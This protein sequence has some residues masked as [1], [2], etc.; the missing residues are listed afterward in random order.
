LDQLRVQSS[1]SGQYKKAIEKAV[2]KKR[3]RAMATKKDSIQEE[4]TNQ[5]SALRAAP[6]AANMTIPRRDVLT[7]AALVLMG[8]A[9]VSKQV[10][11]G[12]AP[13]GSTCR[14]PNKLHTDFM[15]GFTKYF[16]G[17]PA[18]IKQPGCDDPWPG[19][20]RKWPPKGQG[21]KDTVAD[22]ATFVKVLLTVA[23]DPATDPTDPNFT[24]NP[25]LAAAIVKYLNTQ[26]WPGG[27]PLPPI[28]PE[29]AKE[30]ATVNLVEISVI[31]DRLLQAIN[32]FGSGVGGGPSSWPPH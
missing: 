20:S 31:Q 4:R 18:Q 3:G 29:Y 13:G 6:G 32:S 28:P 12:T 5:V 19:S 30:R 8:S 25:T 14:H 7:G 2:N 21:T 9:S 11:A 10:L 15:D 22:Y 27:T 17:D 23:T 24:P 26:H 1:A 16:I